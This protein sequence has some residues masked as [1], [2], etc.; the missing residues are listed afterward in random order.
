MPAWHPYEDYKDF[1]ASQRSLGGGVVLTEIHEIDL[2]VWMIGKPLR[3]SAMGGRMSDLEMDVEDTVS[4]VLELECAGRRIPATLKLSFVQRPVSRFL[5]IYCEHGSLELDIPNDTL[6]VS[7]S[8]LE[9][10]DTLSL[11]NFDRNKMFVEELSEF[12]DCVRSGGE[13]E[14]SLERCLPAHEAALAMLDSLN[15]GRMVEL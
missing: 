11:D 12:I 13:A 4:A 1:Y 2:I 9:D 7:G 3:V 15:D 6:V 8:S 5:G 14:T 10:V